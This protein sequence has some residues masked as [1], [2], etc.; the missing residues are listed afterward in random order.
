[1]KV[2]DNIQI[3]IKDIH[4]RLEDPESLDSP[5]SFG[6]VLKRLEI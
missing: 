1:M 6:I 3:K 4:L 5:Y 2:L